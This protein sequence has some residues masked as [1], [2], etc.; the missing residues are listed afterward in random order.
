MKGIIVKIDGV[1]FKLGLNNMDGHLSIVLS[2]KKYGNEFEPDINMTAIDG[3][4]HKKWIYKNIELESEIEIKIS[5]IDEITNHDD[6]SEYQGV[7]DNEL[8]ILF[9]ELQDQLIKEGLI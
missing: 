5:E 9:Y 3:H 7:Q 4:Q 1:I 8:L 6:L 2:L